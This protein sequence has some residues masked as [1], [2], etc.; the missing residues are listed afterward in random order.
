M[1]NGGG[2]DAPWLR[3]GNEPARSD[4]RRTR[5]IVDHRSAEIGPDTVRAYYQKPVGFIEPN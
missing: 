2:A 5:P 4:D 3:S 1:A